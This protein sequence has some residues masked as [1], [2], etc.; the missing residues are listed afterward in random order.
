MSFFRTLLLFVL[1]ALAEPAL[2]GPGHDHGSGHS[3]TAVPTNVP[4]LES[5]GNEIELVATAENRTLTLYLDRADTNEPVT[6]A[7]IEVS[8][9]DIP[10][11]LAT[12]SDDGVYVIEADWI[13][14]PGSKALTFVVTADGQTDLL[15]GTLEIADDHGGHGDQ[16][17]QFGLLGRS[18]LWIFAACAILLGFFLSFAFRP[19]RLPEDQSSK[20]D[21]DETTSPPRLSV[22]RRKR[23]QVGPVALGLF[24]LFLSSAALAGGD[25]DHSHDLPDPPRTGNAPH[26]FPDGDV[27]LP[28]SSQRL[29]R[30][31]TTPALEVQARPG[32][33]FIGTVIA[34]P[35]SEGRV[36]A[37]MDGSIELAD[38]KVSFVGETVKSGKLLALLAP[39][40]P[41]YERGYL[42][43]LAADVDGKLRIAEQRLHR[44]RNISDGYVAQREIDD[45][46]TELDAL[47]EQQRVLAPKSGQK[48][49]LRAP[50]DGVIAVSNVR[51][52]QVVNT[53]DT[54]F[55]IVDPQRLWIEA[56]SLPGQDDISIVAAHAVLG[57]G[58]K[59]PLTYRGRSP[60]LRNQA[61]PMFFKIEAEPEAFAIGAAVKIVVQGGEPLKG[62]SVPEA[63]VV[64]GPGGLLQIWQKIG[65]ER[66]KPVPVRLVPLDG[67]NMLVTAGLEAGSRLV[68]EGAEFINQVR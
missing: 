26:S 68:V 7:E 63:A 60:A 24:C 29:L 5:V 41:V 62:I 59:V 23:S 2:A 20:S 18:E 66:F 32:I 11:Q 67:A 61:R 54:L 45:T 42:E 25:H 16:A 22:I 40:M 8:G 55:E 50:V 47:R 4:R 21:Q 17:A 39:T 65:P 30:V 15:N 19:V 38:E 6:G 49:E 44:L 3:D 56:V 9:E 52:G 12:P 48:I 35:S 14:A 10:A 36:Q 64:R 58:R 28:K 53:R 57:D 33:E 1:A 51:P 37:P 46:L 31:R 27:F 34:D 13:A 43:Q